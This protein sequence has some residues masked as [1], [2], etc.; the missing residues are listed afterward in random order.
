LLVKAPRI[1]ERIERGPLLKL[2]KITDMV[3][4]GEARGL[5]RGIRSRAGQL[6]GLSFAVV[7]LQVSV[8]VLLAEALSLDASVV[9]LAAVAAM[10]VLVVMVP[11]SFAGLGSREAML[12]VLFTAAGEPKDAAVALGVLLFAVGLAARLPGV[13]GWVRRSTPLHVSIDAAPPAAE[14]AWRRI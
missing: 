8:V 11:I 6:A 2:R 4:S 10:V 3:S 14:E 9:F 1:I 5:F 13:L 7:L 12:V